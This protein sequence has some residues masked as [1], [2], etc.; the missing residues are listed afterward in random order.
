M[1][2]ILPYNR[3]NAIAY[4]HKWANSRNPDYY[5]YEKIG[6]DCTNFASQCLFAGAKVMNYT[7]DFGWYYNNANDKT[8]SWTG[9]EYLHNYL[10][11]TN[12][13]TGPVGIETAIEEIR[14]GDLLQLSFDGEIFL[15]TPVVVSVGKYPSPENILVAAHTYNSDN[16]PLSTYNYMDIRFIHIIDVIR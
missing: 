11:R 3:T 6:G 10:T 2:S 12:K 14:P 4:A 16:R 13:T 15:H 9:V 7:P 1:P 5:D 8:P